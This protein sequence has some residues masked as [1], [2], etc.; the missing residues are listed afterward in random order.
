MCEYVY[1]RSRD[2]CPIKYLLVQADRP[3]A[4]KTFSGFLDGGDSVRGSVVGV[5]P[6]FFWYADCLPV[7]RKIFRHTSCLSLMRKL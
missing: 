7:L 2:V 4:G 5:P 6:K 3:R 1:L